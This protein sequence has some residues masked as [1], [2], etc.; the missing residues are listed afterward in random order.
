VYTDKYKGP[1]LDGPRSAGLHPEQ[2]GDTHGDEYVGMHSGTHPYAWLHMS[3]W[4][5]EAYKDLWVFSG[6]TDVRRS[7][8]WVLHECR[9]GDKWHETQMYAGVHSGCYMS[10]DGGTSGVYVHRDAQ[11]NTGGTNGYT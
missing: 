7:T 9:W 3:R 6:D 2:H 1:G 5:H 4:P 8:Q 10:V 11:G